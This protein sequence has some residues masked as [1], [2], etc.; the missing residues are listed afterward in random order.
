[1]A[2]CYGT[3][4]HERF[5]KKQLILG[6]G[7]EWKFEEERKVN[8]KDYE[9]KYVTYSSSLKTNDYF[10]YDHGELSIYKN[11]KLIYCCNDI[12]EDYPTFFYFYTITDTDY[13]IFRKDDLYGYTILNLNS[14]KEYNYFPD[15]VLNREQESF[16]IV[17]ARLWNEI[18]LLFGCH[19]GCPYIYYLIETHTYKTHML[20]RRDTDES[21]T[22]ITD[23]KLT[24]YYDDGAKPENETFDYDELVKILKNSDSYDI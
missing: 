4:E 3:K 19:W 7:G 1:M 24:I 21:K 13:L 18:L 22:L 5:R 6:N 17:E 12:Y 10:V 9:L 20:C 2:N 11:G 23:N 16:I 8:Y 14:I 15:V